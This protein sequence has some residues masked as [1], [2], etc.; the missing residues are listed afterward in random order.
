MRIDILAK[1][2]QLNA[3]LRRFVEEKMSDLDRM[4]GTAGPAGV[5]VEIGIPSHHHHK[6]PVF[7]AE[8]NLSLKGQLLRAESTAHD[9]HTAIVDVKDELKVQIKRYKEK[10]AS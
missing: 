10:H 8:A 9:L 4:V 5:R 6:G 1:R 2:V 7:Y 3:S